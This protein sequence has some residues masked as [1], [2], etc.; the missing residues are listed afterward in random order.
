MST[1]KQ[2]VE[3]CKCETC[4]KYHKHW[5]AQ[6]P[7]CSC[8]PCA[9]QSLYESRLQ[10]HSC[11]ECGWRLSSEFVYMIRGMG[12]PCQTCKELVAKE[13]RFCQ[14]HYCRLQ[15]GKCGECSCLC[16]EKEIQCPVEECICGCK[17]CRMMERQWERSV[18]WR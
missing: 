2:L 7:H 16:A 8:P 14:I 11:G 5:N 3:S 6:P 10:S 1:Y 9:K 15:D 17:D 13:G 4:V 12:E 18:G